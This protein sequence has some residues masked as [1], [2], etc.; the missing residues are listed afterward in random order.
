VG[1]IDLKV[2][3]IAKIQINSQKPGFQRR[4]Q[5]RMCGAIAHATLITNPRKQL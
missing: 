3:S 4:N 1:D 2:I 5:L